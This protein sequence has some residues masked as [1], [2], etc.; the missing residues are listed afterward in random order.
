MRKP[1]IN[2]RKRCAEELRRVYNSHFDLAHDCGF[3][4]TQARTWWFEEAV[5]SSV[6]LRVL[7]EHG[8][9]IYYIITG[10][11]NPLVGGDTGA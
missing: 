8:V 7:D 11:R 2:I 9:D 1:D 4:V 10:K 5:P 3:V 6:S